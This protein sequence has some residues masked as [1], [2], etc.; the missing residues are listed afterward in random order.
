MSASVFLKT[1]SDRIFHILSLHV[2]FFRKK[3]VFITME[4]KYH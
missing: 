1:I 3:A 2:T 4:S